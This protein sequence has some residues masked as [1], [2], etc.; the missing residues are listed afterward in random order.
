MDRSWLFRPYYGFEGNFQ[1]AIGAQQF[2]GKLCAYFESQQR[3]QADRALQVI[4]SPAS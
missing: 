3:F 2:V 4:G 1:Q